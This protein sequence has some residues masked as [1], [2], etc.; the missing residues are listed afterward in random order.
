MCADILSTVGLGLDIVGVILIWAFSLGKP[1]SIPDSTGKE[2][3]VSLGT[4]ADKADWKKALANLGLPL[5][6]IGFILQLIAV[7]V[8]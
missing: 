2:Y 1:L 4:S 8:N 7:W 6:M 3:S 5:I